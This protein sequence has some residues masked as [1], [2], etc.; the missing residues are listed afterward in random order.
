M[1][2]SIPV[3]SGSFRPGILTALMGASGAG[4]TV[5]SAHC[6][7]WDERWVVGTEPAPVVQPHRHQWNRGC[8]CCR[9]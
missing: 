2:L 7:L 6:H 3:R 1:H 9:P 8:C 5:R 4:K